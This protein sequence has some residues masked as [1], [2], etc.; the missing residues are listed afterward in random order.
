MTH[1]WEKNQSIEKDINEMMDLVDRAFKIAII[2]W[3]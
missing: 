1:S 3:I 2:N